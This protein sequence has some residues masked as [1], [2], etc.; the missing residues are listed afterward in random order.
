MNE[1]IGGSLILALI[2]LFMV[3]VL[4]YMAFNVN[5]TKAFRMKNKII[6]TYEKYNGKCDA[7]CKNEI[8]QYATDIGYSPEGR[9]NCNDYLHPDKCVSITPI[10]NLYCEYKVQAY[11]SNHVKS[12]T[13][14]VDDGGNPY[15]YK[16]LTR[17]NISIPIVQNALPINI[18]N[19]T[20][21]TK[22]FDLS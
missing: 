15:Y 7:T 5:Y 8:I 17:T 22:V 10:N 2:V 6:S 11:K 12:G 9:L 4:S 20:G 18:L 13:T 16:I 3:F 14:I 1:G 19:S 21:D